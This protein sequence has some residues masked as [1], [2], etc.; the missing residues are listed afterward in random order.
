MFP[1]LFKA[2][3]DEKRRDILVLLKNGPM[4]AGSLA[5]E[6]NIAPTK[7]TYHLNILKEADLII[8]YKVKNFVYFEQNTTLLDEAILWLSKVK[9]EE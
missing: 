5:K 4:S 8:E 9:R 2:L 7:L 6:L 1:V 3:S